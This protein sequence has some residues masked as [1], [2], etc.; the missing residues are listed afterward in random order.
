MRGIVHVRQML[1]VEVGI[2]LGGGQI[3]MAKQF[4]HRTQI[5]AG[6]QHMGG[7]GVTQLVRMDVAVN[8]LLDA[9][10]GKTFLHV[11]GRDAFSLIGQ[12]HRIV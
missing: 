6:L 10:L 12:E 1:K 7:K 8:A 3:G 5:A 9:P 2:D 11:T 4:L